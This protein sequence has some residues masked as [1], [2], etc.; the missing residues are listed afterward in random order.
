MTAQKMADS[1]GISRRSIELGIAEL[2]KQGLIIGKGSRKI[3]YWE[4]RKD[5]MF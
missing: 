5:G 1:I 2:K 3:G 4:V